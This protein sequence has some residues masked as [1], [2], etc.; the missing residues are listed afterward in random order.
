M[1]GRAVMRIRDVSGD[2]LEAARLRERLLRSYS[3]LDA[4]RAL[5][6]FDELPR[7]V[8]RPRRKACVGQRRLC[9]RRRG[10]GRR[11]CAVARNGIARTHDARRGDRGAQGR[12]IWRGRAAAV[13]AGQR[14]LL[15]II[16]VPVSLGAAGIATDVSQIEALR[17]DMERQ[18]KAHAA[19]LDQLSTAVAIFDR[20]KRLVFHNSAYRQLWSL[21]PAFLDECPS[22]SEILDRLRAARLLPEQADFRAWKDSVLSA[23]QAMETTEQVW[24]LPDGRTLRVVINPNPQGG[25]TY[26]FDDVT[27]RFHLKSRFNALARVQSETLD[28]LKEGVAVFGTDGR[29]NFFNPAFAQLL[30]L[31]PAQLGEKPHIDRISTSCTIVGK[32]DAAFAA[33]RS[34]V[35]GLD[36][37]RTGYRGTDRVSGRHRARQHGAAA[38]G[39]GDPLDLHRRDGERQRR[40]GA[41][42]AQQGVD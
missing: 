1:S 18:T 22:D 2:R 33:I 27:E 21:P 3:E 11:R 40:A 41:D 31:D 7:L 28:T 30:K 19:T 9:P 35:T 8:A 14:R 36:D 15:D 10:E 23:Y 29:L 20:R 4:L 5:L 17:G 34:V 39:R 26:L 32:D 16:E 37:Q 38:A 13:A 24:Y 6:E 25:V 12:T 42:R